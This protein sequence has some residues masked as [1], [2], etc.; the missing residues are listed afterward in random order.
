MIGHLN[1][2][3]PLYGLKGDVPAGTIL[4][5]QGMSGSTI[6]GPVATMHANG[7]NGYIATPEDLMWIVRSMQGVLGGNQ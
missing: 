4:G 6:G 5:A 3:S 7:R 1:A 2:Q